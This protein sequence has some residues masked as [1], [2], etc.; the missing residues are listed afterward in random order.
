M[1]LRQHVF[2]L[3]LSDSDDRGAPIRGRRH[4]SATSRLH[5]FHQHFD[6]RMMGV[7]NRYPLNLLPS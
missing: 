6:K 4:R 5:L 2:R 1:P 3:H 7:R